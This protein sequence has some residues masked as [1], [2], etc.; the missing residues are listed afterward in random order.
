MPISLGW[1]SG[2]HFSSAITSA[3]S[4]SSDRWIVEVAITPPLLFCAPALRR[5]EVSATLLNVYCEA[6]MNE[7]SCLRAEVR[8]SPRRQLPTYIDNNRNH[9]GGA[10]DFC[11]LRLVPDPDWWPG[12]EGCI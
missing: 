11:Q 1:I 2:S 10:N 5:N 4:C 7:S 9:S 3:R 8:N 12:A 6:A